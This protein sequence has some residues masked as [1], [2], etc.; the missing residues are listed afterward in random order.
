MILHSKKDFKELLE[1]ITSPLMTRYSEKRA[2]LDIGTQ[3]ACYEDNVAR[4]EAFARILWGLVPYYVG[5]E[6]CDEL[7][8]IYIEGLSNGTD[9]QS[10]EYWGACHDFDQR[11]VEMASI[12]YGLIFAKDKLWDPLSDSAKK[13]LAKW[14]YSINEL[15]VPE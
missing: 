4:M 9:P 3:R 12:A 2:F 7:E 10:D 1:S 13:N 8:K 6:S 5:G 15:F 14:L 11:F